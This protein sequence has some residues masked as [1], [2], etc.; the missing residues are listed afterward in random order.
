[1]GGWEDWEKDKLFEYEL[2]IFRDYVGRELEIEMRCL[3]EV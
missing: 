3:K 1:M 2:V